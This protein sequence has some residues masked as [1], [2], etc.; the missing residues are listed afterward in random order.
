MVL[1]PWHWFLGGMILVVL[2]IFLPSFTIFWFGLAAIVVS[3]IL[4]LMPE[5]SL[6][7]QLSLW[8]VLSIMITVVW[9]KWIKPLSKNR[10]TA[11]LSRENTIGQI[12]MVIRLI[13]EHNEAIVRFAMPLLG[14]DEW[15]CRCQQPVQVGQ[16]VSVIDIL[17][18][19]LLIQPYA[20]SSE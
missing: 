13:P 5:L 16:R 7:V 9:F 11:G 17:G 8:I 10:T 14:S 12:G 4:W 1:Q 15:T 19:Q 18:N 2:E 20:S 6:A 3:A